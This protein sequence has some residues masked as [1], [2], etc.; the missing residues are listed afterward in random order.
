MFKFS[1]LFQDL[2]KSIDKTIHKSLPN[3]RRCQS[4]NGF[5]IPKRPRKLPEIPRQANGKQSSSDN[6]LFLLIFAVLV[7]YRSH[8]IPILVIFPY[9][10]S[11]I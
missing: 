1:S 8:I 3:N 11:L 4:S 2:D 10:Y 9:F 6:Y 7:C 5:K